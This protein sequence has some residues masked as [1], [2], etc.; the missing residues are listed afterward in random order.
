[1][2]CIKAEKQGKYRLYKH[3]YAVLEAKNIHFVILS[4]KQDF[5]CTFVNSNSP[6]RQ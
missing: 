3:K 6:K 4:R 1:M 2:Q 5:Y